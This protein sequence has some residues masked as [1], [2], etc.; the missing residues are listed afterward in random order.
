MNFRLLTLEVVCC[1]FSLSACAQDAFGDDAYD[2]EAEATRNPT[3][4]V[5]MSEVAE[6]QF[7]LI[8]E[9]AELLNAPFDATYLLMEHHRSVACSSSRQ[10]DSQSDSLSS[11]VSWDRDRLL[12]RVFGDD[13]SSVL[14][15]AGVTLS[16]VHGAR[17]K[18]ACNAQCKRI[19]TDSRV[20]E[21]DVVVAP[22][23]ALDRAIT[24]QYSLAPSVGIEA[25]ALDAHP[26][27]PNDARAYQAQQYGAKPHL[28]P[29][30]TGEQITKLFSLYGLAFGWRLGFLVLLHCHCDMPTAL[31]QLKSM[32]DTFNFSFLSLTLT[33]TSQNSRQSSFRS[34]TCA[35]TSFR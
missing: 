14:S 27:F 13:A 1:C 10:I 22:Q 15:A 31:R 30:P 12:Q 4:T 2:V 17:D 34:T 28:S 18:A 8:E 29:V 11:T 20:L 33:D 24:E 21:C 9:V 25:I 5:T 19:L 6:F 35:T 32:G 16:C 7:K 26:L 3:F 23:A